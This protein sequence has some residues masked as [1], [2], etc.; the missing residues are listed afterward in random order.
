[1][2]QSYNITDLK[3]VETTKSNMQDGFDSTDIKILEGLALNNPRNKA[4]LASKLGI[5]RETLRHRI[6][7]LHSQFSLR[8]Q[9]NLYHTNIGL[10]KVVVLAES[11]AGYEETLYQCLKSNDYWLYISQCVGTRKCLVMYG[12]PAGK[13]KEF[14]E[15]L[16]KLSDLDLV[17]NIDFFWSTCIQ[18][19]NTIDTWFDH[20]SAQWIFPWDLWLQEVMTNQGELPYTLKDPDGYYQKA[21]WMDIIILKELEKNCTIKLKEIAEK[22]GTSLQLVKYH[23]DNHVIK[24][25][26]FEGPQ[27]VCEHYKGL[28]AD[29]YYFK[30]VFKSHDDF[31]RFACSLLNKPFARAMGKVYG[32]N[33]L[34]A[35]I[36]LPRQQ[37]RNFI[38]TLS[39]L[40]KAGFLDTYDYVLLDQTRTQRDT[41]PYQHFKDSNWEYNHEQYLE[42]LQFTFK[43]FVN[44]V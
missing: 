8:L 42:K 36:Y 30:F 26:M 27:V 40:I 22:L 32:K 6:D 9:G 44:D 14:E 1:M 31:A 3:L 11:K 13:E 35:H 16:N 7:Y 38:G 37:F 39:K 19:I 29:V 23:F 24:E 5:P 34:F 15:F 18:A 25:Q 21:D 43:Q 20:K 17:S 2:G 33:Q 10:R 4:K 41:I 28:S 12:I